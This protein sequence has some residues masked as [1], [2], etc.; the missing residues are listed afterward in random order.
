MPKYRNSNIKVHRKEKSDRYK[1]I[2]KGAAYVIVGMFISKFLTYL[3]R[4]ITA[5]LGAE[6]YGLL[7][8]GIAV[9]GVVSFI[10]LMGL[11]NGVLRYV[12]YYR[13]LKKFNAVNGIIRYCIRISGVLSC[14][15]F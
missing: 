10:P 14:L 8:L 12:A 15:L 13:Q 11:D 4:M 9:I 6:S 7:S 5:R 1:T 3:Y 2:A